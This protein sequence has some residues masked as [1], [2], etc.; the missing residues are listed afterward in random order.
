[1]EL[2]EGEGEIAPGVGFFPAP[3][4]TPGC[5]AVRLETGEHGPVILAGDAIKHAKEALSERCDMAFD[6]IET[7]TASIR[8]ILDEAERI[9]PGHFQELI[10][11]GD[12]FVW[13]DAFELTLVVR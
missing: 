9:V 1:L 11:Q 4:H 13:E 6:T 12:R 3:G 8:R 2:I 5:Y 7:G 10:R